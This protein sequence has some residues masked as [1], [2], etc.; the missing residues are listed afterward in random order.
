M[1]HARTYILGTF[2]AAAAAVGVYFAY[3]QYCGKTGRCTNPKR[4]PVPIKPVKSTRQREPLRQAAPQ[5]AP[6]PNA[7]PHPDQVSPAELEHLVEMLASA[8]TTKFVKIMRTLLQ[9]SNFNY[10]MVIINFYA[11]SLISLRLDPPKY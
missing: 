10:N 4:R 3:R 5:P 2:A 6:P 7:A 11:L 9:F 1:T 8:N